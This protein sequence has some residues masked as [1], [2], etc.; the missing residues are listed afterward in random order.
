MTSKILMFLL[1]IFVFSKN[2]V[3]GQNDSLTFFEVIQDD[4]IKMYFNE[5]YHLVE[6]ECFNY[7]RF[8]WVDS[9]GNFN[10]YFEDNDAK[11]NLMSK[12]T[13]INGIKHGYFEVYNPE[14]KLI[15]KGHYHKNEPIGEWNYFYENGKPERTLFLDENG[16]VLKKFFDKKGNCLVNEG[17][18]DFEGLIAGSNNSII[19]IAKGKVENGIPHG[20]WTGFHRNKAIYCKEEYENGEFIRGNFTN[21]LPGFDGRYRNNP[22]LNNLFLEN[23]LGNLE[24]YHFEKCSDLSIHNPMKNSFNFQ[25]FNSELRVK[26]DWIIENDFRTGR[27]D[28]YQI[29][30]NVLTIKFKINEEGKPD[31]FF[32][33]SSWGRQ[34]Y[35]S[36]KTLIKMLTKF[37][38]YLEEMYFHLKLDFPGGNFYQY[39]FQFSKSPYI[40]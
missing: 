18:G 1:I 34:F 35:H 33:I 30:E 23:Y 10:G 20:K 25:Q 13:Y 31:E 21:T 24:E 7:V 6:K 17:K 11:G 26:V 4:S 36:I 9:A 28:Y 32:Q 3:N 38:P 5:R 37:P 40:Q 14:T 16:V 29:G 19:L 27:A 8:T 15:S 39:N 2:L 22:N 12:G